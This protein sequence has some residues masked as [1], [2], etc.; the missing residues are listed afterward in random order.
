MKKQ[1]IVVKFQIRQKVILVKDLFGQDSNLDTSIAMLDD[2]T[3]FD[4]DRYVYIS[5]LDMY[6]EYM[7]EGGGIGPYGGFKTNISKAI[8]KGKEIKIY[9][10]VEEYETKDNSTESLGITDAFTF[11]YTFEQES[12]GN[13]KFVSRIKEESK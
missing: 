8:K 4:L 11:V 12:A 10:T 5:T 3:P 1:Q 9:E 6:V 7:K 2:T 13:Y